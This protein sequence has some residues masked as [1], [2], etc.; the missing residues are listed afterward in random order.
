MP[1]PPDIALLPFEPSRAREWIEAHTEVKTP[2][3]VP[4]IRLRL[5]S[6][7]LLLAREEHLQRIGLS[8]PFWAF[9]WPG[10]QA[11]ARW[12]L[13]DPTPI[14]GK[15]VLEVGSG[16]GL[17]A[18]AA[19][20]AG[21]ASVEAADIDPTAAVAARMN[22]GLNGVELVA[23]ARD[24]VGGETDA[25]VILV[26]D[27]TYDRTLAIRVAEW[28][29]AM[30]KRGVRALVADPD[31]GFLPVARLRTLAFVESP[32]DGEVEGKR[33]VRTRISAV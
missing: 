25:E 22:A 24:P 18:I 19:A 16:S 32:G 5:A 9:A 12:L 14:A 11:L 13:D 1:R 23:T 20:I 26:A 2:P 29:L 17:V 4:E 3:L 21:A 33:T 31:R 7:S 8:D 30:G 27:T 10:G 15:R 6:P 28:V